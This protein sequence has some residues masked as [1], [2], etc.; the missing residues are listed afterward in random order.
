MAR[1]QAHHADRDEPRLFETA[2]KLCDDL[3]KATATQGEILETLSTQEETLK[4]LAQ[5]RGF[6]LAVRDYFKSQLE[7]AAQEAE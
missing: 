4:T 1:A 5:A 3:K 2:Q 6:I 7:E